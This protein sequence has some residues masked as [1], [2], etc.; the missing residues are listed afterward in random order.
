[1]T[2]AKAIAAI[3]G[4]VLEFV[5]GLFK[6]NTPRKDTVKREPPPQSLEPD[7]ERTLRDL[8]I[9]GVQRPDDRAEG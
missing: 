5:A 6:T 9:G 2:W 8:G 3:L 1:M 7:R 4:A